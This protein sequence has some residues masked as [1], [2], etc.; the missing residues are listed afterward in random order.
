ME[1][2]KLLKSKGILVSKLVG[3]RDE[4][5][6]QWE[7]AFAKNLSK[8]QKRKIYLHQHLWHVFSYKKLSCL[9]EQKARDAFNKVK[10]SGCYI[11]YNDNQNVLLLG[12]DKSLRAED[13]IKDVDDFLEDVYVV[14]TDFSW[15]Y[16]LTH[17][18]Y[19]GPYFYQLNED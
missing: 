7:E 3:K 19:C 5:Q 11:F 4:L 16:V 9:E 8:S 14:D 17:E 1:Q 10:K 6:K 18:E 12:N 15:T 2:I 13:L